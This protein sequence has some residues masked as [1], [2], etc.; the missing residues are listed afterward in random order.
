VEDETYL[1]SYHAVMKKLVESYF[2]SGLFEEETTVIYNM[3]RPC[4][5]RDPTFFYSMEECENA[6]KSLKAFGLKR[7]ESIRRQLD[8]RLP[9]ETDR[10]KK[11]DKVDASEV[12]VF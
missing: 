12:S 3:I 7:A 11:E 5:E 9:P 2:E 8:G 6:Y 10:H 4:L 1:K